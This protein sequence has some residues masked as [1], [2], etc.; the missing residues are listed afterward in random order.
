[1]FCVARSCMLLQPYLYLSLCLSLFRSFNT[2]VCSFLACLCI[3]I[4]KV[5]MFLYRTLSSSCVSFSLAFPRSSSQTFKSSVFL[6]FHGYPSCPSVCQMR[7]SCV[8]TNLTE[9]RV[10]HVTGWN[11]F[12]SLSLNIAWKKSDYLRNWRSDESYKLVCWNYIERGR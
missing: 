5:S 9:F 4:F 2:S 11:H 3:S 12:F 8:V 10:I 7:N 6:L 1:M